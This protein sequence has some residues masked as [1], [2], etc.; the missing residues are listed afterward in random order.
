MKIKKKQITS[1][2]GSV[3]C[4]MKMYYHLTIIISIFTFNPKKNGY[5]KVNFKTDS[6]YQIVDILS[7]SMDKYQTYGYN[8]FERLFDFHKK[9]VI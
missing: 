5:L 6:I 9:A 1:E 2:K 7:A 3:R 4:L 8:S